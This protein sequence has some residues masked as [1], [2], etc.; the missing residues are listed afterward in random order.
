VNN[1]LR[2]FKP[3]ILPFHGKISPNKQINEVPNMTDQSQCI[4]CKE[5]SESIPQVMLRYNDTDYW[6]CPTH[7]P[8]LIHEPTKLVGIVPGAEALVVAE[9]KNN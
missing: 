8:L 3:H 6:M 4:F 9:Q 1:V 2:L 5:T 7:L